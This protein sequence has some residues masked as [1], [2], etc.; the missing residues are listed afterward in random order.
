MLCSVVTTLVHVEGTFGLALFVANLA[1]KHLALVLMDIP[2]VNFESVFS[3]ILS[4]AVWA[5][6]IFETYKEFMKSVLC[7]RFVV[8]ATVWFQG[9]CKGITQN[10][11]NNIFLPQSEQQ[12]PADVIIKLILCRPMVGAH[13]N[14]QGIQTFCWF[15]TN[16]TV[17]GYAGVLVNISYMGLKNIWSWKM[18]SAVATW[19]PWKHQ[20]DISKSSNEHRNWF[21]K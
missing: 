21:Y 3:W 6:E 15:L 11:H 13:V 14:F 16:L 10:F 4:S 19:G 12:R 9:G 2:N 1:V 17:E 5:W 8:T 18:F 20:G 7:L